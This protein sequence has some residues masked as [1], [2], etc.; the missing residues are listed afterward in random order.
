MSKGRE[1]KSGIGVQYRVWFGVTDILDR[2]RGAIKDKKGIGTIELIFI[3]VIVLGMAIAF[4]DEIVSIFVKIKTAL[5]G[6]NGKIDT[7]VT[8]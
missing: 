4:R 3:T 5:S 8:N 6:L 1:L 7:G 2:C